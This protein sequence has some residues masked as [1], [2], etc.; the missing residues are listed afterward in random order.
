[1]K[2]E[3]YK[4]L[5][6]LQD[7]IA[8]EIKKINAKG[9]LTPV[10][11]KNATDA[12]CLLDKIQKIQNDSDYSNTSVS[13]GRMRNVN[14]GRYMSRGPRDY[15]HHSIHDRMIAALEELMD[16]A[17]SDYDREVISN[18]IRMIRQYEY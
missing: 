3:L 1:M 9:D 13:Y 18:G 8:K 5:D 17:E 2:E 14:T 16:K 11:L 7:L 4:E 15:S 6:E 12:M 10:E